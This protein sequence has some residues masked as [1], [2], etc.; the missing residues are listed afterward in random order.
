MRSFFPLA[1]YWPIAL[2]FCGVLCVGS[3]SWAQSANLLQDPSFEDGPPRAVEILDWPWGGED[4]SE[5]NGVLIVQGIAR[6]GSQSAR[7]QAAP[8]AVLWQ[9][10]PAT[11][12]TDYTATCW[13]KADPALGVGGDSP[14]LSIRRTDVICP[15]EECDDDGDEDLDHSEALAQVP[16]QVQTTDWEPIT[17]N[18][19]SGPFTQLAIHL[20]SVLNGNQFILVDDCSV[21]EGGSQDPVCGEQGCTGGEEC[22]ACPPPAAPARRGRRARPIRR[23]TLLMGPPAV[24]AEN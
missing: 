16:L 2:V 21:N 23:A 1:V 7:M 20:Y 17:V 5:E 3:Q 12:D 10:F 8:E 15:V 4:E 11:P 6:S 24:S 19:N 13:I 18:F 9:R 22:I 14:A